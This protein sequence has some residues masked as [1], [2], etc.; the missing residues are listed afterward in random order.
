M[1]GAG[2]PHLL[3]IRPGDRVVFDDG[4]HTVLGFSGTTVRLLSDDGEQQVLLLTHLQAS[5]GFRLLGAGAPAALAGLSAL[6]EV[7]DAAAARA[8]WWE[9]HIIEVE[10]GRAP[11]AA[12]DVAGRPEYDPSRRLAEREQAKAAELTAAGVACS[13]ATVRRRRYAYA[14]AGLLGLVDQ[15]AVRGVSPTGRVDERVVT[16]VRQ[17]LNEQTEVSTG[18]RGRLRR[19]VGQLLA[20]EYGAEV[21]LPSSATFYRLVARLSAGSH[22][23]G[24]ATTRRSLAHRPPRPFGSLRALRPGE[25]VQ[26]DTTPLDVLVL[27]DD[28][29]TGRAELTVLV[30][31]ATRSICAGVL[32]PAGTKAV[33]AALL[34]ARAV[35]PEP[36]RPGW[37][38]A[39]A[40][41]ASRLPHEALIAADERLERAAARPVIVPE[42]IVSDRGAVFVSQTFLDA[43]TRLGISLHPA[44]PGTPTDKPT[45]ERTFSSIHTLFSQYVAGYTGRDVSRRG[46]RVDDEAVWTVPQLQELFDQWVIAGWA[47]RPHDGLRL[48]E[49][50]RAA[51]SPN[52]MYAALVAAAGYLPLALTGADYLELLPVAWRQITEGGIQFDVLTYDSPVLKDVRGQPCPVAGRDGRWPIHHD[53]YDRGQVWVHH[54]ETGDWLEVPWVHRDAVAVP[55]ADFTVRHVRALLAARGEHTDDQRQ[56][57]AA[58]TTLLDRAG[59]GPTIGATGPT[60][61]PG[62]GLGGD[63]RTRRVAART[64]C[65]PPALST[66]PESDEQD[67]PSMD[68]LRSPSATEAVRGRDG[69]HIAGHLGGRD[70]VPD[71]G[72]PDEEQTGSE[73]GVVPFGLFDAHA[74]A[75]RMW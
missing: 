21:G 22:A 23:F 27:L 14:S 52:E 43:C 57:A 25:W 2:V 68:L 17:A 28:G 67:E 64:R 26:I 3:S 18:T 56:I 5:P 70:A 50:P 15:R 40:M 74:E 47:P 59:N 45:V 39:L 7:P 34:L 48:P 73:A 31:V 60:G 61:Q 32:R 66:A 12:V 65:A 38:Q 16:A 9:R 69:G 1:S 41:R 62:D 63:R 53:P 6:A 46:A 33:D 10:T 35:V 37:P 42:T 13:A 51:L 24:A 30:D 44:R 71:D 55:F 11:D 8:R 49:L 58:L 29:V 54:P 75:M 36:M 20:A 19:R 4:E 72:E